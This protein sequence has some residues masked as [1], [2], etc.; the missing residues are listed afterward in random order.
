MTQ[1]LDPQV[2]RDEAHRLA[3][4]HADRLAVQG[5][6]DG[7]LYTE[8]VAWDDYPGTRRVYDQLVENDVR[9]RRLRDAATPRAEVV[10]VE[11]DPFAAL[12]RRH[13]HAIA[14]ARSLVDMWR[15][16]RGPN[17]HGLLFIGGVG[18]GKTTLAL[19]IANAVGTRARNVLHLLEAERRAIAAR[20]QLR[21]WQHAVEV[22]LLVLDDLGAGREW[23]HGRDRLAALLELRADT[24]PRG[25][26]VVTTNLNLVEMRN[27]LGDRAVSRLLGRCDVHVL[28]GVDRRTADLDR[29]IVAAV[30]DTGGA[31]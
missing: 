22:G 29:R 31:A 26:E 14:A 28:Q 3:W 6:G 19:A 17:V 5:A 25:R 11:R 27:Y 30:P 15:A 9:V 20:E 7:L 13:P 21:D 23:D 16:G 2:P 1:P 24:N 12:D 8:A 10:H 18:V 4:Q